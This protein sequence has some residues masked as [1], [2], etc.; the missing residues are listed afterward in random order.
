MSAIPALMLCLLWALSDPASPGAATSG[1]LR[2]LANETANFQGVWETTYGE[3][4]LRQAGDQV[5]GEYP[6]CSDFQGTVNGRR[7]EF[8]YREVSVKG[9]GWFELAEDQDQIAGHWQDDRQ[10]QGP[11]IGKL[12]RRELP[13][14]RFEGLWDTK[15]GPLRLVQDGNQVLGYYSTGGES[16]LQGTVD[17]NGRLA[18]QYEESA[19]RGEGWFERADDGKRLEG[20]WRSE[21]PS[22]WR[23]WT[24]RRVSRSGKTWLVILEAHWESSLGSEPYAFGE[25]L[26]QYFEMES[27]RHVEVRHRYFHDAEDFRRLSREVIYLNGPVVLL[28]SSHGTK[29][30]ISVNGTTIGARW[31]ADS[32]TALPNLQLLHLSGCNMME[33]RVPQQILDLLPSAER[34][35]ISG[36]TTTVDWD[37]SAVSDFLYLTLLLVRGLKP[38]QAIAQT[39]LSAPFTSAELV[40]GSELIPLGLTLLMPETRE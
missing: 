28:V 12:V 8:Q 37:T 31:I 1:A 19:D 4:I 14:E 9:N 5:S 3:L 34:F 24:G 25:M 21:Q 7:L 23:P 16:R 13:E 22:E 38:E 15:F 2:S 10:R 40:A 36:Y 27:A 32:L 29:Q 39:H 18:F 11:W 6:G 20:S 35:P 33:G 30:G 26:S 17:E